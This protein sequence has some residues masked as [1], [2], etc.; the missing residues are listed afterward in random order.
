MLEFAG[1]LPELREKVDQDLQRRGLPRQKVLAVVVSLLEKTLI[2][3]GNSEYA[4][5]NKSFGL[6]TL[7]NR[8]IEIDGA[9]VKFEFRGKSGKLWRLSL[10][11]RRM[12]RV[13]RNCQELPG[14]HLFQYVDEAGAR[15]AVTSADVNDYLR[16]I[17][18]RE[19]TAKDFRTWAGTWLAATELA[20][21]SPFESEAQAKRN[22]RGVIALV[23]ARLG[24]TPAICRKCYIHP[25]IVEAYLEGNLKLA[26]LIPDRPASGAGLTDEEARVLAFLRRRLRG[27]R[28]SRGAKIGLRQG[29]GGTASAPARSAQTGD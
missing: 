15:T 25:E 2:R 14:Q 24:N 5:E 13:I 16:E 3:V 26:P 7:R 28:Q 9:Q 12:A 10:A 18:G 20:A 21:L 19:I 22:V 23:A 1:A 27:A 8:H 4:R 29:T 6:T 11:D 17:A